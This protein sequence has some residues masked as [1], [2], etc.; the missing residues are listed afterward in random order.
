MDR[1]LYPECCSLLVATTILTVG[2]LEAT[3][4]KFVTVIG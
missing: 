2:T 4:F 3:S 1:N